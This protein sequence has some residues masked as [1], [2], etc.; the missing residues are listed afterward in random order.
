MT[1]CFA[2]TL[3]D[4]LADPLVLKLMAADHVDAASLWRDMT[5][6]AT[7]I[8]AHPLGADFSRARVRPLTEPRRPAALP[9]PRDFGGCGT[10]LCG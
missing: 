6:T 9:K 8:G 10:G 3:N 1:N 7:R 5:E 4:L 2:P